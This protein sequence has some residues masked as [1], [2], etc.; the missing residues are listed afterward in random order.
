MSLFMMSR[1]HLFVKISRKPVKDSVFEI[2]NEERSV[3]ELDL[4]APAEL[5][6]LELPDDLGDIPQV[7]G[8]GVLLEPDLRA[9]PG[10]RG[11]VHADPDQ[12]GH[13]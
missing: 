1:T 7:P 6:L 5:A 9:G 10:H 8:G 3:P 12:L 13:K 2:P 4:G 11:R